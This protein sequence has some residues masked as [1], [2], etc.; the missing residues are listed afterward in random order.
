MILA[1]H[2]PQ[3]APWLGFFDKL[4]SAD[5]F[6]LLDNVQFK[7]NEWQNRNRIKTAE[8][9]QWLTVP[10]SFRFGDKISDVRIADSHNW[11]HRHQQTL[12][13]CYSRAQY[14]QEIFDLYNDT[15]SNEWD[16]LCELNIALLQALTSRLGVDTRIAVASEMDPLPD[17]RDERLIELCMRFGA[18]TYLAGAGGRQYM[19]VNK[20]RQTE[21][22]VNFQDY[23]HPV[24]E[25][26]FGEFSPQLSILDLLFNYGTKSL[27]VIR[28]GRREGA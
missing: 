12:K 16:K 22:T 11:R 23:Q 19:Q 21:V 3:F 17:G 8:G 2:Q 9:P 6:V 10:V 25:Q 15:I 1:A 14:F 28:Q 26:L 18:D 13:T 24:Y 5:V 27:E 4:D 7:K 20:F